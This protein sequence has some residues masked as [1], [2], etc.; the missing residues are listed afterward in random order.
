MITRKI[1]EVERHF[2]QN[3]DVIN[4][5]RRAQKHIKAKLAELR[6]IEKQH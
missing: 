3:V 6:E 4:A 1:A 2:D 5:D